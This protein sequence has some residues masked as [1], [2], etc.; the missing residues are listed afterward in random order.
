MR[1]EYYKKFFY[2]LKKFATVNNYKV[3]YNFLGNEYELR[4]EKENVIFYITVNNEK[5][6]I[7]LKDAY[8]ILKGFVQ[9]VLQDKQKYKFRFHSKNKK[10][11]ITLNESQEK[12]Y[13]RLVELFTPYLYNESILLTNT[14]FTINDKVIRDCFSDVDVSTEL[15]RNIIKV[16]I[17]SDEHFLE[18][19][20]LY[21]DD[22]KYDGLIPLQEEKYITI[23]EK[24]GKI[25]EILLE[26]K[27]L[28]ALK[29]MMLSFV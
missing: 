9:K 20:I 22:F 25:S 19:K 29:N 1:E 6:Y 13:K 8:T 2:V 24:D 26:E 28:N 11:T 12:V 21:V 27:F 4:L 23:K 3:N 14:F 7:S 5:K 15:L 17:F 18:A 10:E 16:I